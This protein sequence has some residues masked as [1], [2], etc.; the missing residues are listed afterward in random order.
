MSSDDDLII[1]GVIS[2]GP[3]LLIFKLCMIVAIST[4]VTGER[5][6]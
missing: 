5:E 6:K 4:S 2:S 3:G 1:L